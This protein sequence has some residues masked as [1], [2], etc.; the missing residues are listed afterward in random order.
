MENDTV[1]NVPGK[2]S[3]KRMLTLLPSLLLG[4]LAGWLSATALWQNILLFL[5][6]T[7]ANVTDPVFHRDISFYFFNLSLL[8]T[9]ALLSRLFQ[10]LLRQRRYSLRVDGIFGQTTR[11]AVLAFRKNNGLRQTGM[12]DTP[13]WR[14]LGVTCLPSQYYPPND[15]PTT[16]PSFPSVPSFPPARK[17]N[18]RPCPV[19]RINRFGNH[20]A[21]NQI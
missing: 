7:P 15:V 13:T 8:E 9:V 2:K 21:M 5:Q 10:N 1:I 11:N 17:I 16:L 4:L 18:R 14:A 20:Q 12:V 3:A 6:Q 19:F